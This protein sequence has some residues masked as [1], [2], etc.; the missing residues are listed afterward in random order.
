MQVHSL[1]QAAKQLKVSAYQIQK[2]RRAG[3][4]GLQN[5][6]YD[7]DKLNEWLKNN[8]PS[9]ARSTQPTRDE[10]KPDPDLRE[11]DLDDDIIVELEKNQIHTIQQLA[12]LMEQFPSDPLPGLDET[13]QKQVQISLKKYQA[14]QKRMTRFT[15]GA[16]AIVLIGFLYLAIAQSMSPRSSDVFDISAHLYHAENQSQKQALQIKGAVRMESLGE[17]DVNVTV[18]ATNSQGLSYPVYTK[19][20]TDGT[21]QVALPSNFVLPCDPANVKPA[22]GNEKKKPKKQDPKADPCHE[23]TLVVVSGDKTMGY[24]PFQRTI[25][26]ETILKP[27]SRPLR[28]RVPIPIGALAWV[29]GFVIAGLINAAWAYRI[30]LTR[31]NPGKILRRLLLIQA[32]LALTLTFLTAVGMTYAAYD[33]QNRFA[34]QDPDGAKAH[35]LGNFFLFKGTFVEECPKEWILALTDPPESAQQKL[36]PQSSPSKSKPADKQPDVLKGFGAPVWV[37]FISVFG[38][39]LIAVMTVAEETMTL[40]SFW[41]TAD[42]Q[43]DNTLKS[44]SNLIQNLLRHQIYILF[45]PFSGILVYQMLVAADAAKS[46]LL[47]ASTVLGAGMTLNLIIK[48]AIDRAS[49]AVNK[50]GG[51]S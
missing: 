36:L 25:R 4:D 13:Q 41:V 27:G 35:T 10:D 49:K 5:S 38:A 47:V 1:N 28:P 12:D 29:F 11:L 6:P 19:T 15:A 2:W 26:G 8:D 16:A 43:N 21:F 3:A 14:H 18:V 7:L 20:D 40:R 32:G 39:G 17:P 33:T 44:H 37:V 51:E 34:E 22:N 30:N 9:F 42:P 50:N 46:S 45:A 23:I 24:P 48:S 31:K